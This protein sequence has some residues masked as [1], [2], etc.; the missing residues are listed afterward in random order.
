[1]LFV[2]EGRGDEITRNDVEM[3][4]A[5]RWNGMESNL[6]RRRGRSVVVVCWGVF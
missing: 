6:E 3:E 1:M 4:L 2:L 5:H